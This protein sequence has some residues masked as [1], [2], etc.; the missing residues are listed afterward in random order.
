LWAAASILLLAGAS[1]QARSDSLFAQSAQ[2]SLLKAF[3]V[4]AASS[5]ISWLLMDAR[6]GELLASRWSDAGQPVPVGSL[7]KP[8][9]ALA[10]ARTHTGFPRYACT[11]TA[12]RC[13]LPRGHGTLGFEQALTF[14]CNSYFLQLAKETTP[15][16]IHQI[17]SEYDLPDAP[18]AAT[19]AELIGLESTWRI[20]PLELGRAYIRLANRFDTAAI[21]DGMRRAAIDGTADALAAEDALAKTGTAHCL[22]DCLAGGDG[23]VVALTPSE[24][25]RLLLLVRERGT[26][27]AATAAIAARM[28]HALRNDHVIQ[29]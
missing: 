19:P 21:R 28:L 16:A 20:S 2:A 23:F 27:G 7:T 17:A 18:V 12:T 24:N 26:N 25:P 5:R 9:I 3:S 29:Y 8:F 11:G 15:L 14:S 22:R 10:Y 13:W 4:D 6:T 1:G